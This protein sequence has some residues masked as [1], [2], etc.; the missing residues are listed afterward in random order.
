LEYA[1]DNGQIF[2]HVLKLF[3]IKRAFC[4]EN[5]LFI[6]VLNI[7]QIGHEINSLLVKLKIAV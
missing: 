3:H 6:L 5:T 1:I 2:K 7:K 4:S